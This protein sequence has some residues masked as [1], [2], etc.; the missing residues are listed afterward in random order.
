MKKMGWAAEIYME[1]KV[2]T[3]YKYY[4][5]RVTQPKQKKKESHKQKA[6]FT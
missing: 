2:L 1:Y 3:S 6:P 4:P 5:N